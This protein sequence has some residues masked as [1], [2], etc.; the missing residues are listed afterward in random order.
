MSGMELD[1]D[2]G[3]FERSTEGIS[4]T[5]IDRA[6]SAKYRLEHFYKSTVAESADRENR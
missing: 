2:M 3:G 4:Q 6:T 5:T 1:D